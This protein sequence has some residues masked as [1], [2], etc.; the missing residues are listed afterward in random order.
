M[1]F[2]LQNSRLSLCQ[3]V[4]KQVAFSQT[5]AVEIPW[6][7]EIHLALLSQW[8]KVPL[9]VKLSK[10]F[11]LNDITLSLLWQEI[12][13]GGSFR[14]GYIT[15]LQSIFRCQFVLKYPQQMLVTSHRRCAD[16]GGPSGCSSDPDRCYRP[17]TAYLSD[18][19]QGW[20]SP[21]HALPWQKTFKATASDSS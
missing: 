7:W 4:S 16:R 2:L 11:V 5:V 13:G 9:A 10:T 3:S 6:C 12:K 20:Y 15:C 17:E 8:G 19:P 21:P 14:K 1:L 18:A